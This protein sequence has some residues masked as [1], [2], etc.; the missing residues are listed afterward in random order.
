[1]EGFYRDRAQSVPMLQSVD[2]TLCE[3]NPLVITG[4]GTLMALDGK[5]S[6]D[7]NALFRHPDLAEMRDLQ[8]E[9]M[10]ETRA[11]EAGLSYVKL[12]GDIGCMVNGAG[13]AMTTM[14]ITS[15]IAA[16]MGIE[17]S[18][19]ANFL[20]IGGGAKADKSATALR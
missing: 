5:I 20:D 16:R 10:E 15:D 7:D 3:I 18:G 19:P 9:P 17:G 13:L 8:A 12:D 1:M 4:Q 2:A 11:R 14:D 6:I